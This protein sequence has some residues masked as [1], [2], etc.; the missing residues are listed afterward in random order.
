MTCFKCIF[1]RMN[2]TNEHFKLHTY[3]GWLAGQLAKWF[4]CIYYY[5]N[6]NNNSKNS[7]NLYTGYRKKGLKDIKNKLTKKIRV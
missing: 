3:A 2:N 1:T 5:H 6:N 4:V 7:C